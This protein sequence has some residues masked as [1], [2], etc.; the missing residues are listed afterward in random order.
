MFM[1]WETTK[2]WTSQNEQNK[3]TTN[4]LNNLEVKNYNLT[5]FLYLLDVNAEQVTK[6]YQYYAL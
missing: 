4:E 2:D 6:P 1:S 3:T 5:V